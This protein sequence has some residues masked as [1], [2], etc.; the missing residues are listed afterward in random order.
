MKLLKYAPFNGYNVTIGHNNIV[1]FPKGFGKLISCQ[2][3]PKC[4]VKRPIE[5]T[6]LRRGVGGWVS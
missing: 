2:C 4:K 3:N 5:S 1:H 6:Q